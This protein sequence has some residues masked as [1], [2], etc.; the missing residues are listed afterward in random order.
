MFE[1][2]ARS[3]AL[4]KQSARVLRRDKQLLLFP[5]VSS[6]ACLLV[7]ASFAIPVLLTID[8]SAAGETTRQQREAAAQN[9]VYY[10]GVFLFY[11][12]NFFVISFFN[13]GLVACAIHR[14][15]GEETSFGDGMRVAVARLPQILGWA[16]VAATVGVV[17]KMISERAGFLGKLVISLV[18][19]AWAVATYFV[20]P[21]LVVEGLGPI[22]AVKRS[23]AVI[24]K[25]WGESLVANVGLGVAGMLGYLI[26]LLPLGLGIAGSVAMNSAVPVIIG[27]AVSLV[28]MV[29]TGLILSALGGIILAAIY[30]YAAT[31]QVS[32]D[33]DAETLQAKFRAKRARRD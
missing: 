31:G 11:F 28:L 30:R 8:F 14:M 2:M 18:G 26:A 7:L 32:A 6:V 16:L 27:A 9:P 15:N 13:A 22:E 17:L 20:V 3:W 33:F 12:A 23:T 10:L 21:V 1:R 4:T 24:R 25:T 29:A 5:I 19:M